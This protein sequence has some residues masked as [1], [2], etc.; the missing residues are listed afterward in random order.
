MARIGRDGLRTVAAIS[1]EFGLVLT[2]DVQ[3]GR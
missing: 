2:G 1:D 3:I